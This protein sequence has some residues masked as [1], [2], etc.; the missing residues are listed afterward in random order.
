MKKMMK[1]QMMMV[2]AA[3]AALTGCAAESGNDEGDLES[4]EAIGT[5]SEALSVSS[6]YK[7]DLNYHGG[8]GGTGY[9]RSCGAGDVAIGIYGTYGSYV[10]EVGLYCARLHSDGT[11]G[12]TYTTGTAGKPGANSYQFICF[13]GKVVVGFYGRSATYLDRIGPICDYAPTGYPERG[14]DYGGYGGQDFKDQ[15]LDNYAVTSITVRAGNWVDGIRGSCS[16]LN[17]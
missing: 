11:L 7:T 17:P 6:T 12:P 16:Y 14:Y 15:C 13:R 3:M 1:A 10:N 2:V 9:R 8:S 5:T 4:N